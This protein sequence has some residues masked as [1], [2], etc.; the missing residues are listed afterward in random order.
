MRARFLIFLAILGLG[1]ALAI[2]SVGAH[3]DDGGGGGDGLQFRAEGAEALFAST[4]AAGILTEVWVYAADDKAP[5]RGSKTYVD[6]EQRDPTCVP[7]GSG[8]K[9]ELEPGGCDPVFFAECYSALADGAFAVSPPQLAGAWLEATLTCYE[10]RSA[11]YL[12]MTVSMGWTAVGERTAAGHHEQAHHPGWPADTHHV[13]G[14]QRAAMASGVV[15]DGVTNFTPE[16]SSEA[17]VF[18]AQEIFT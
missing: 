5:E 7:D 3:G 12:T 2:Q 4:D 1:P 16:A 14:F 15:T 18:D 9:A 17:R 8:P 6:V 13:Q 10:H 11:G